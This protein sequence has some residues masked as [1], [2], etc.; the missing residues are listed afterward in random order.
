MALPT[1][2]SLSSPVYIFMKNAY[3]EVLFGTDIFVLVLEV[4]T[5]RQVREAEPELFQFSRKYAEYFS[6]S[7]LVQYLRFLCLPSVANILCLKDLRRFAVKCHSDCDDLPNDWK[8]RL[9]SD[10]FLPILLP[11]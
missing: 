11:M 6:L 8:S 3:L 4:M 7:F 10:N 9:L 2:V 1:S 5:G